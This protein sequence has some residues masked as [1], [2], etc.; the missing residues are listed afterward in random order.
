MSC[1]IRA[2][3]KLFKRNKYEPLDQNDLTASFTDNEVKTSLEKQDECCVCM[4]RINE[5]KLRCGHNIHILCIIESKKSSCPACRSDI[6]QDCIV[7]IKKCKNKKCVCKKKGE[8]TEIEARMAH[9]LITDYISHLRPRQNI[10]KKNL[11]RLMISNN[12]NNYGS[13]VSLYI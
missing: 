5:S 1:L 11:E 2:F 7:H 3:R 13:V 8:I 12:I 10:S 9:D 6:S 4:E